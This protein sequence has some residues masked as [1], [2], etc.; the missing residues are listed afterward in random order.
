MYNHSGLSSDYSVPYSHCE[1]HLHVRPQWVVVRLFC[2]IFSLWDTFTCTITVG[3]RQTIL[4]HILIVRY[5]YM[6][7]HNGLS[8]DYSVPYSHCEIHLH[9]RPQWVVVR[10][11]CPIFSLWNTFTCTTTMGCR[12]T[13][14][15]H[16]LIVRYI[17][18]YD[19]SGLSSDYSVPYSHC[20]IHLHVRPQWVVVRLFCPIFSLWD[21]FT[22]TTTMG[23]RQTILSHIL[24]VRYIY[25]YDHNGLSSDYSVPYSHCEIHLH[26]RPQ[27]V[28]VR[29]FCPIFSLWDT[30]TC[31]TTMGCRQTILS[32]ILIVRYIY[33]C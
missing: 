4:S 7:D 31:T 14:L 16:I 13:I 20:E 3:C 15:S 17:Y 10:L 24:I 26:V 5:I 23:C 1:I 9:V 19:H 27:W 6:Y 32:H 12:Q 11:F 30:F 28:V 25:M 29:L 21:T 22:C 8:S 33:M 2:P 18:M